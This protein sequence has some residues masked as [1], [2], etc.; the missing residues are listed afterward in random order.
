METRLC[1]AELSFC[2][3]TP[4][5]H[6]AWRK[7]LARSQHRLCVLRLPTFPTLADLD[8]N[9]G[10][11]SS[12][13]QISLVPSPVIF[14]NQRLAPA[15]SHH[16]NPRHHALADPALFG[17]ADA[18]C[19]CLQSQ[20]GLVAPPSPCSASSVRFSLE[21]LLPSTRSTDMAGAVVAQ[22]RLRPCIV[23]DAAPVPE[24]KQLTRN[25][26]SHRQCRVH[27]SLQ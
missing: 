21:V 18:R 13:T 4:L 20:S 8:I 23:V 22:T 7:P 19:I 6:S 2:Y 9:L 17:P 27:N 26:Q 12:P 1:P 15:I 10:H 25:S 5:S 14:A 24:Q 16:G 11:S 3:L